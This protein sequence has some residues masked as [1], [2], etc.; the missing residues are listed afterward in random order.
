[1]NFSPF[2]S[3]GISYSSSINPDIGL[4]LSLRSAAVL[5]PELAIDIWLVSD[6]LWCRVWCGW[7]WG[8]G[9]LVID[10]LAPWPCGID[11][12]I[13]R[14]GMW[15]YCTFI[16]I[17]FMNPMARRWS[18]IVAS[19]ARVKRN[20]WHRFDVWQNILKI[21]I[22]S[23]FLVTFSYF[24]RCIQNTAG[25]LNCSYPR[26]TNCVSAFVLAQ[27]SGRPHEGR[28]LLH[29]SSRTSSGCHR[30]VT[31]ST[32]LIATGDSLRTVRLLYY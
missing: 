10:R 26:Q 31:H 20:V 16:S 22:R 28:A 27:N 24:G 5:S 11:N 32:I 6:T 21:R 19:P 17:T 9:G 15:E 7:P 8:N 25:I 3:S 29:H 12:R 4:E 13:I 23:K 2:R 18:I 1:M 30:N 14:I